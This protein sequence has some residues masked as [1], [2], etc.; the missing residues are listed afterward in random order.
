[1]KIIKI[2]LKIVLFPIELW[3]Y[4]IIKLGAWLYD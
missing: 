1:M 3:S 2:I 4:L